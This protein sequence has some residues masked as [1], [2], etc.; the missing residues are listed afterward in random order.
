MGTVWLAERADGAFQRQVALK[1]LRSGWLRPDEHFRRERDIL[2]RLGHPNIAQLYDGGAN[3]DQPWFALEY[4][5]GEQIVVWCDQNRLDVRARVRLMLP[6]CAAVQFAHQHLVVHRDIKPANVLVAADGTPKLLDFGIAKLIDQGDARQTQ[7]FAMTPAYASPEQRRGETVRTPSDV[8]QLGLLLYELL[9][10]QS[11]HDLRSRHPDRLVPRIDQVLASLTPEMRAETGWARSMSP[12]RLRSVLRGDLAR[13]VDKAMAE[14]EIE[15][16]ESP[17]A[18][19]QDLENWL[20]GRPVRAHRGNFSYRWRKFLRR[21]WALSA[22]VLVLVLVSAYYVVDL[23]EKSRSI[24]AERDQALVVAGFLE[25]L[26]RGAN[27]QETGS[28]DLS[29]RELLDR[30]VARLEKEI[31]LEPR[32]RAQLEATMARSYQG[33]GLYEPARGLY[34]RA[35]V[36]FRSPVA[37]DPLLVARTLKDSAANALEASDTSTAEQDLRESLDYL[38]RMERRRYRC[39]LCARRCGDESRQ[40]VPSGRCRPALRVDCQNEAE[41]VRSGPTFFC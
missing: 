22:A 1:L 3:G 40:P 9:L 17:Q 32:M 37:D 4:V 15:R 11:A 12:D 10:G 34:E 7:T 13:I 21:N 33:L 19:A 18:L 24:T 38:A 16:Y 25:D 23:G 14:V 31:R 36:T 27:P 2:A 29:A 41:A 28:P 6:I 39:R 26:F 30:G 35:L 5:A 8:Y 20:E